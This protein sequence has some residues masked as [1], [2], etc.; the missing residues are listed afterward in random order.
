M[1]QAVCRNR[2]C[3]PMQF[4]DFK[5]FR[6]CSAAIFLFGF[7]LM[8]QVDTSAVSGYVLD[9][10][11]RIIPNAAV[12]IESV[13]RSYVRSAR[14]SVSG[15]YEFDGLPPAEY[16]LSV[17][18]DAFAP[19][20]TEAIQI[21]VDRRV[22]LD[23]R[24]S[25]AGQGTQVVVKAEAPAVQTNS[26]ELGAV[27]D[28]T[29][30]NDLPLNERDFLQLAL[31]LPGVAPPVQGSQLSTRGTFSM[32]ANGAR[33]ESNNFLLDGVDNNDTDV[34]GYVLEPSVDSIQEFKIATNSYSAEYGSASASQVNIITRSGTNEFHGT[35]YDYLRNRDLDARNFFDGS[36]KPQFIRNQFGASLGGP[37]IKNST[38]FFANF[39]GL[40]ED[41]GQTQ[42]GIVP[43]L[44]VRS[45][46]LSGLGITV[47]DPN[48]GIP[49]PNA[50]VPVSPQAAQVLALFPKPNLPGNSLNYLGNPIGTNSQNEGSVR[51]DQRV[52]NRSQLTFRYN[53]G[54]RDL[55][56][57]Y[58]ETEDQAE[59]PVPGFGDFVYDRGHNALVH[60]EQTLSPTIVNS[61]LAGFN[62]EIRQIFVQNYTTN[63]NALWGVNYLPTAPRDYGFPGIAVDGYSNVGDV[64]SL[65]IN[66]ADNTWQLGDHLTLVR[67]AHSIKAGAEFRDLQ[68]N[69]YVE[70]YSRGQMYFTGAFTGSGIADLLLGLPTLGIKSQ[71]TGPQTLRTKSLSAYV[72]DDWKVTRNLTL[73]LGLRYEYDTPPTDPTNRMSTF[74]FKDGRMEESRLEQD[75]R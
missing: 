16:R 73:N 37:V 55:F 5:R 28:Q 45:G 71:Y 40:R 42:L 13:A 18:A 43:T 31:L 57:P 69:G 34:R 1:S 30:V 24:P 38:F 74:N 70:V 41:Q 65:P 7:R 35:A 9:P 44:A 8:A 62:R 49:F 68:E 4:M 72:Q 63:V 50:R 60:Y 32:D 58:T 21:E 75:S 27:L 19:L 48:T 25:I 23:L 67:G 51:L 61:I 64:A 12:R 46:D 33:E 52:S 22:R 14:S 20:T 15:Y 3:I 6:C 66:R 47:V 54:R 17:N 53:Y 10:S 26:S 29:L 2:R 56:E 59:P 36:V 39:E 11:G